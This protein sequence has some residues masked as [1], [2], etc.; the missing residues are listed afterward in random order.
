V[1]HWTKPARLA[2]LVALLASSV[3]LANPAH[4]ASQMTLRITWFEWPPADYLQQMANTLYTPS[5]PNLKII[6]DRPPG[7]VWYQSVFNQFIT[8]HT[9]FDAAVGD[10]QWLGQGSTDGYYVDLT[11]WLKQ[12]LKVNDYVTALMASYG[13]YPQRIPGTTGGL[14]LVH[15]HF[16]GVPM[17]SDAL[18]WAYRK[19]L[20]N[21]PA[22]KTAYQAQYHRPLRV[23]QSMDELV[24]IA[25]F[26]TKQGN[27][28][29]YGVAFHETSQYDGAAEAFNEFLWTYGGD[30]WNPKTRQI[31][32]YVNSPRAVHALEVLDHLAK[33]A[34]PGSGNYWYNEVNS[35]FN[36]GKVA[37]A[38][39]WFGFMPG[40]RDPK[41]SSLGKTVAELDQKVGY[42]I[43]PPETY[44][45]V[46]SHAVALGGQG[47]S[48]SAFAPPAHQKAILDFVKWFQQPDIQ[49]IWV[50]TGVG[51]TSSI[52]VLNSPEFKSSAPY[53]PL[54]L[55]AFS[56]AR[57]FWNVPQYAKML[58]V[59]GQNL[60]ASLTG[61]K[62]AKDALDATAKK[63][64]AILNG[65]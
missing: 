6:V 4:A 60:N 52:A 47:L 42:F 23:P 25:D 15:G 38:N 9:T 49:K 51:G 45:G 44:Q 11:N 31:Q 28:K 1:K 34:P 14:D 61:S 8:H 17:E 5:H 19:D 33:D 2:A 16:W 65:G 37:L 64:Q 50:K 30:L 59:M 57:D 29:Y 18:V 3:A 32:G 10:S 62:S 40:L 13:Q 22:N 36:Q 24:D 54:E 63:Q 7:S 58:T 41:A 39:N 20:F 12:N 56:I 21:D 53:A 55:P 35:A 43:N 46:T 26:F 27:G 48:I